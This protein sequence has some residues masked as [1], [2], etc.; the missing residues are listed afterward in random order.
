MPYVKK[1]F[2]IQFS[3]DL[4]SGAFLVLSSWTIFATTGSLLLTGLYVSLGFVPS[5]VAN[6][7]VGAI[8]DRRDSKKMIQ[9]AII[10]IAIALLNTLFSFQMDTIYVLYISQMLLQLGG[11]IFRPSVQ[12]YM[13]Q[14]FEHDQLPYLYTKS[15]SISIF[16]GVVGT[17]IAS[18]LIDYSNISILLLM[19][20]CIAITLAIT[21]TLP[22]TVQAKTQIQTTIHQD[23]KDGFRYIKS[24]PI[25]WKLFVILGSGQ[26][27]THC[28]TGFL[29]AYTYETF[30]NNATVYGYL[31]VIL[32][33][34]GISIGLCSKK[35]ITK[36]NNILSHIA[37]SLLSLA[38][39]LCVFSKSYIV[40]GISLFLIGLLTTWIR[41][42][43]QAVQQMHTATGFNGKMAS[44]RM[45]INQ[46]SVVCISPL[47]GVIASVIGTNYIFLILAVISTASYFL[48]RNMYSISVDNV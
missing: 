48:I 29:A 46:G 9:I 7:Y 27:I 36:L 11:S 45:I 5:L 43:F 31:Q 21:Y 38:L 42:H 14:L 44:F 1:I 40:I 18:Q 20:C 32:T 16:G 2:Y 6:L 41:S 39:I 10:V 47:L 8:V 23:L 13:T 22:N 30:A 25:F 26:V 33:I 12:V 15:A 34:G 24:K 17:F 35:F 3:L 28:T 37:F 19:L 4:I